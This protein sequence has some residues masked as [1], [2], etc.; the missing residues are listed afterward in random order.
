[1][2]IRTTSIEQKKQSHDILPSLSWYKMSLKE[3]I[4]VFAM[5]RLL[6]KM[7]EKKCS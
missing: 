4:V 1:M 7:I 6:P 2:L 5:H 3:S